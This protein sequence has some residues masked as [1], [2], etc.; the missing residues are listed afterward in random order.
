MIQTGDVA[1]ADGWVT[2]YSALYNEQGVQQSRLWP[3]GTLCITIAANIADSGLLSFEACFPDSVVGFSPFDP[4]PDARYFEYF[5]RTA[6]S[7]LE[8]YAPSTAQ[9]NINLAILDEL[10]IPVP[11]LIE[12]TRIVVRTEHLLAQCDRLADALQV[13]SAAASELAAGVTNSA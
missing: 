5:I 8:L 13:K 1:R 4:I 10:L 11:P 9:K 12:M 2:T 3:K 6:Q 7:E